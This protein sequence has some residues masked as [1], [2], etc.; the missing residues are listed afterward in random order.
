MPKWNSGTQQISLTQSYFNT[1]AISPLLSN[2]YEIPC[3]SKDNP[4]LRCQLTINRPQTTSEISQTFDTLKVYLFA[5][6]FTSLELSTSGALFRNPA[7]TKPVSSFSAQAF[8]QSGTLTAK[9]A[10]IKLQVSTAYQLPASDVQI[11]A[12]D[13][14]IN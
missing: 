1:A 10:K 4:Y 7:S 11:K 5:R 6:D 9:V 2:T 14:A 12:Q 8:L 13:V 3:K